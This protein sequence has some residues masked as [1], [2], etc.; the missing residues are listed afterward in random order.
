MASHHHRNKKAARSQRAEHSEARGEHAAREHEHGTYSRELEPRRVTRGKTSIDPIEVPS[1]GKADVAHVDW[2][3]CTFRAPTTEFY[4]VLAS[5][6]LIPRST[7]LNREGGWNGYKHRVDLGGFG[8][9]AYGGDAQRGTEHLELNGHG[10]ARIQDW[11]AIRV[12]CET[13]GAR[14]T[15][16]DLAHD[17]FDAEAVSIIT[18]LAWLQDGQFTTGGR[19]PSARLIDDLGSNNGKTLYV[20]KRQNGKLCRVY[21]K[22]KEQGDPQSPWCRVEVEFRGKSRLIPNDVVTRPGDYLAGAYPCLSFLTKRQDKVKTLSKSFE[23]SYEHLVRCLRT[24]YG[25]ALT[26]MAKVEGGDAFAVLEQ[27]MRPGTPRRLTNLPLPRGESS[28]GDT[29]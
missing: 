29:A 21:E 4:D 20:G 17:D 25:P 22:G 7:W 24:Q 16:V 14:V 9:L 2:F 26:V 1:T 27:V 13:Y 18:A 23:V 6:F 8:L 11:N 19:P 15:R 3:A 10:C 5:M 28:A 12:W